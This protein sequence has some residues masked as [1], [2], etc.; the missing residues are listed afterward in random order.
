MAGGEFRLGTTSMYMVTLYAIY[1][2]NASMVSHMYM[3][4]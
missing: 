4:A 2:T 3:G 1:T